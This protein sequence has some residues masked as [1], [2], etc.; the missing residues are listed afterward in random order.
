MVQVIIIAVY[1]TGMIAVG[2]WSR[3]KSR[4]ADDFYVAGR[5]GSTLFITGSLL[6]TIRFGTFEVTCHFE[7]DQA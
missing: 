7:E 3:R 4:A 5:K 1:F 2:L 6:A